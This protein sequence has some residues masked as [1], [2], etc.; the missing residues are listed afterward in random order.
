MTFTFIELL[1]IID[2]YFS[3]DGTEVYSVSKS[4][5]SSQNKGRQ[6]S[7]K[8]YV[9]LEP[10]IDQLA[11]RF[12]NKQ[13]KGTIDVWWIYDDGGLTILMPF[14]LKQSSLW[15]GCKLRVFSVT[16]DTEE[17]TAEQLRY[18]IKLQIFLW[19]Y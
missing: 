10:R 19:F 8:G 9:D 16:K 2:F 13:R 18:K 1:I 4:M 3:K 5:E 15:R 12:K 6:N 11:N 17:I 14:I 7:Y